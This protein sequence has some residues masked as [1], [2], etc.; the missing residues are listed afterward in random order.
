MFYLWP[1]LF[2]NHR[3]LEEDFGEGRV[4]V[5]HQIKILVNRL[6]AKGQGLRTKAGHFEQNDL[7]E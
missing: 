7:F 6:L 3:D 1:K 4:L 5:R 2:A